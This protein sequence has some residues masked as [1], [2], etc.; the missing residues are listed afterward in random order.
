MIIS[1][2][3]ARHPVV[4]GI[5]LIALLLFGMLSVQGTRQDFIPGIE[6]PTA[7]VVTTWPGGSPRD[8]EREVTDPLEKGLTTLA[9]VKDLTSNSIPP[10]ASIRF[11]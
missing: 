2:Y 4:I 10:T 3:S 7:V 1:D 8:I 5:L 6:L 9:N 11:L